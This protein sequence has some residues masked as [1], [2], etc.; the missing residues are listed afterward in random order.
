MSTDVALGLERNRH[1]RPDDHAGQQI[2]QH[3]R[4]PQPLEEDRRDG[5]DAQ[6]TRPAFLQ[7]IRG[8]RAWRSAVSGWRPIIAE[9]CARFVESNSWADAVHLAQAADCGH[10]ASSHAPRA[11]YIH[12][13]FCR[14][15]CGYCNFTLVAGRDDLIGDYLRA[16]EIGA[17]AAAKRRAKSTRSISAAARR[18]I[19]QPEQFRQLAATV[20][21]SA[22]DPP[23]AERTMNGRS[24]P[25]RPTSTRR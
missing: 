2:A 16:I 23:L 9:R 19:L 10:R 3:D 25:I 11:A 5:R 22:G 8:R 6:S 15:R 20:R 12:V 13:P 17:G 14:H 7:R 1:V 24:R 18:R 4:L 21:A